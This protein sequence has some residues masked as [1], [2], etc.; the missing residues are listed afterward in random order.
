MVKI[1]INGFG[2]VGRLLLRIAIEKCSKGSVGSEMPVV[3]IINDSDISPC[4]MGYLLKHDTIYGPLK[5]E[6][7]KMDDC[8]MIEGQ[9]I[10]TTQIQEVRK[11][12]W[13]KACTIDYV[14]D[15]T[16]M[17]ITCAAASAHLQDKIKG[18]LVTGCADIPIFCVGVN[19]T[20]YK[21]T[22][23]TAS[24]GTPSLNCLTTM[25]RVLQENFKIEKATALAIQP[26]SINDKILDDGTGSTPREG[27]SAMTNVIPVNSPASGRFVSRIIPELTDKIES[28]SIKIPIPCVGAID[29]TAELSKETC[30]EI[31]GTKLKEA[32][33]CYMKGILKF[34][35]EELVSSD[36]IGDSHSCIVD[37]KAG[38]G[39]PKNTIKVFGWYDAEYASAYRL[40]DMI[41]YIAARE[42]CET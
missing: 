24:I 18:V 1:G 16:G 19:H 34:T 7:V 35:T 9:R 38:I 21:P 30:F 4:T 17:N 5:K 6:I 11:I 3:T 26:L 33:E 36:L 2:R 42:V 41:K 31:V 10:E 28:T 20:C 27:R 12:P 13:H 14:V 39:L 15:T 22:I 25:L 23:K 29:L 37:F 40:Y 8:I 32:S